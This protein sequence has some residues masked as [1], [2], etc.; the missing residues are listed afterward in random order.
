MI[1][2]RNASSFWKIKINEETIKQ[3]CS[4]DQDYKIRIRKDFESS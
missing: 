4:I 1:Y 2:R 3:D